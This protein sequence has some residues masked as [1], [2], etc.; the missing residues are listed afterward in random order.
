MKCSRCGDAKYSSWTCFLNLTLCDTCNKLYRKE[1]HKAFEK[2]GYSE[3][4]ERQFAQTFPVI[5]SFNPS[6]RNSK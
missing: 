4:D 6:N 1:F 2:D 3:W 5:F